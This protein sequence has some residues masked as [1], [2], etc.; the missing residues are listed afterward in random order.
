MINY[1]KVIFESKFYLRPRNFYTYGCVLS[2]NIFF[3]FTTHL[4]G[5]PLSCETNKGLIKII[6]SSYLLCVENP[7]HDKEEFNKD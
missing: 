7:T 5:N 1:I 6:I 4:R 2:C 3:N